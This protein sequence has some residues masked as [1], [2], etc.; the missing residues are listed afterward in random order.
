MERGVDRL[1]KSADPVGAEQDFRAVLARN[2][3]H[4]GARYQLAVALDRGGRPAE[5]R[6]E[7]TRVLDEARTYNDS[8][9]IRTATARLAAPDTA[10]AA[11]MMTLGV[12]LLYRQNNASAAEAQFRKV[13]EKNPNHYGATYQL[14]AALD[15]EGRAADA[16]P[17]WTRVLGMA[18]M[19]KDEK[20]AATARARLK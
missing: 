17:L 2:P 1:Y 18:T 12:D 16:R 14:A 8:A 19:Y 20:T 5:A 4:Y 6:S 15:K 11:A 13:L 3:N 9:T 7:W 10:S